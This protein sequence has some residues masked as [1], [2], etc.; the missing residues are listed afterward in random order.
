M[1]PFN[2]N[3]HIAECERYLS[4]FLQCQIKLRQAE[5]LPKSTRDVAW[6]LDVEANGISKSY[7]L[8]VDPKDSEREYRVLRSMEKIPIP[9]PGVYGWDPTGEALGIPCFLSDY[10]EGESLLGAMLSGEVW[11]EALYLDAVCA[12]QDIPEQA[13]EEITP[14]LRRETAVDVLENAQSYFQKN[15]RPLAIKV[16]NELKASLPTLPETRF[17][18]GDLWLDNFLVRDRQLVGVIDFEG[19]GFSDPIFEFLLSFFVSPGLQRRGIEEHF[20]QRIGYDPTI[21]VWYHGLE[22]FD[23]WHWVVKT[24][25]PF[26]HYTAD[27]LET[28][29][30]KWLAD[31][32]GV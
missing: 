10:I 7:V 11:A 30:E 18:N 29:L 28:D 23:T 16:Y 20:C 32:Q 25:E 19:A 5:R 4:R 17:S 15:Q 27:S 24:G 8:R 6:R 13:F 1:Q 21:L 12:L 22:F 9:T 31:I 26:V 2:P 14:W 3:E